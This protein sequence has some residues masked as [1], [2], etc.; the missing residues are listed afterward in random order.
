MVDPRGG[1]LRDHLRNPLG[2]RREGLLMNR[3]THR[4]RVDAPGQWSRGR[5]RLAGAA[6]VGVALAITG[7]GAW[8]VAGMIGSPPATPAEATTSDTPMVGT[9]ATV[10]EALPASLTTDPIGSLTI[11]AATRLGPAG[12]PTGFPATAE[13]A[14]SQLVAI[15]SAAL[16]PLSLQRAQEIAGVWIAADGLTDQWSLVTG[17][18]ELQG[19]V[20]SS[21]MKT[22]G[23]AVEASMGRV[24]SPVRAGTTEVC[25][26]LVLSLEGVATDQ[27]AAADCQ[28]M[29]WTGQ[30]WVIAAG[31][32]A[33][34]PPSVWP[35]SQAAAD[36]GWQWLVRQ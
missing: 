36:A 32:E 8:A 6:I 3:R 34:A 24:E 2:D 33:A 31:T 27:I 5:L 28:R 9:A 35:G 26:D 13:G 19:V 1:G 21:G 29:S 10:D 30:R 11:P 23:L 7:A 16:S 22:S 17:L 25:V 20:E 15:D 12:V 4:D 14:L 18:A